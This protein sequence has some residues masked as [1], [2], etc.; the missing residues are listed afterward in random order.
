MIHCDPG[1]RI[2]GGACWRVPVPHTPSC[3]AAVYV[4]KVRQPL[5]IHHRL[6]DRL[7]CGAPAD[8]TCNTRV[9][10]YRRGSAAW[11]SYTC[12][13]YYPPFIGSLDSW[14]YLDKQYLD[15]LQRSCVSQ[16]CSPTLA[17]LGRRRVLQSSD[18]RLSL[19]WPE[20]VPIYLLGALRGVATWEL[21]KPAQ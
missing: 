19:T 21:Q 9:S 2:Q 6:E 11:L 13:F 5:L 3:S 4:E 7:S 17:Y 18:H 12:N 20:P 15:V 16:A 8:V 10:V 1:D 14:Q